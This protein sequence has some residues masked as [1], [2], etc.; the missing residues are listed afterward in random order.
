[1]NYRMVSTTVGKIL[2]AEAILLLLPLSVALYYGE[3]HTYAAFIGTA[4]LLLCCGLLLEIKQP[5][6]RRIYARE[7]FMIVAISWLL[8]SAFGALP[9]WFTGAIAHP[10]DALFETVSGF[11]TTGATILTDIEALPKSVLFWRSFTHWIGGMGI[12]VFVLAFL[13]QRENQ[14]MHIMRAEVPGPTM[15]KLV[16]KSM[17]TARILYIIY[18]ALTVLEIVLLLAGGMPLF[19]SVTTAFATAGTGGFSVRNASIAAYNS[20]YAE[21]VISVFML[22]FGVN[23]N[24]FFLLLM[25][26]FGRVFKSEEL[27]WYLGTVAFSV[28][29]IALNILP[30]YGGRLTTAVRYAGF[31]VASIITTTGFA[32]ADYTQWPILSQMVLLALFCIGACAGST[33]GGF[34]IERMMVLCKSLLGQIK[35]ALNSREVVTVKVD[36][37]PLDGKYVSSVVSYLGLYVVVVFV[38]IFLIC[39]DAVDMQEAIGAVLTC[40]NNVGPA[41]GRLSPVGNFS[42]LSLFSKLVLSF[43]MLAGRLEIYPML[44][45]FY[46]RAWRR[47]S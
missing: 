23:F 43:L 12:L 46:H 7:G 31:Q 26:Q 41:F 9:F 37:K 6:H 24:L 21:V 20:L 25:R 28:G 47:K 10:V 15:G 29:V 39:F 42:S 32:T 18:L 36:G 14:S 17:M 1:M 16:S 22:L 38:G 8:I 45:V 3:V 2:I 35:K 30:I 5:R 44:I 13:P 19:D 4:L 11:T 40:F 33:G 27:R 34:K